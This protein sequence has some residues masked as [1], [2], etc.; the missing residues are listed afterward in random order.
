MK[1]FV[2]TDQFLGNMTFLTETES[3]KSEAPSD[4]KYISYLGKYQA[5]AWQIYNFLPKEEIWIW[6]WANPRGHRD[7][8]VASVLREATVCWTY[9]V[10]VWT[11]LPPPSEE[12][13]IIP[14][15]IFIIIII[16]DLVSIAIIFIVVVVILIIVIIVVIV[17]IVFSVIIVISVTSVSSIIY[18]QN[19]PHGR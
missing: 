10:S 6:K 15:V 2:E 1:H 8:S 17:I 4:D 19:C 3:V 18:Q 14:T 5:L 12:E 9:Y 11:L 7:V 13:A 16:I